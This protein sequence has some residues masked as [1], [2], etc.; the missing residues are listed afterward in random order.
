MV[1]ILIITIT[2]CSIWIDFPTHYYY[3]AP[4]GLRAVIL[5]YSDNFFRHFLTDENAKLINSMLFGY[6]TNLPA[7]LIGDF[8]TSGLA[9]VLAVSGMNVGLIN[10][11]ISY[12]LKLCKCPKKIRFFVV[13]VL[14]IFYAYLCG[15]QYPIL[16][17]T[18]MFLTFAFFRNF[19]IP[20]DPLST[21]CFSAIIILLLNPASLF[22][23]SFQLS[24]ACM[25]ALIAF[26]NS[27]QKYVLVS[28]ITCFLLCFVVTL[29]LLIYYF[30][31][32]PTYGLVSSLILLPLLSFVFS[33]SMVALMTFAFGIFLFILDPILTFV[34]TGA[35][36][37]SSLPFSRIEIAAAGQ[38]QLFGIAVYFLGLFIASKYVF[39][40]RNTKAVLCFSAFAFYLM[41]LI[42]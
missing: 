9:H 3:E 15:F 22:S 19:Q 36:A 12:I 13:S 10:W 2:I 32:I 34:R 7:D 28:S 23:A 37:I 21:L 42:V 31:Y 18:I 1:V 27:V 24:Y 4:K 38:F 6:R 5:N 8:N 25:F 40:S 33:L 29:P 26:Y 17:S 41:T 14:L 11:F 39:L 30:G 20:A 35:A 16:R